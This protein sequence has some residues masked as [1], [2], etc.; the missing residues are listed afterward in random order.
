MWIDVSVKAGNYHRTLEGEYDTRGLK[1][2]IEL[3]SSVLK[4]YP[5]QLDLVF[6]RERHD[7][8]Y[9][10]LYFDSSIAVTEF[11]GMTLTEIALFDFVG[12][13]LSLL[14]GALAFVI[15]TH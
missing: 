7:T 9:E 5:L 15:K 10:E 2:V 4:G 8:P 3:P 1:F 12:M 14:I 6:R 13:I 11:W